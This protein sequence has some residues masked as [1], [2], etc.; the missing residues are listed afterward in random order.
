MPRRKLTK[1]QIGE[2]F[3]GSMFKKVVGVVKKHAKT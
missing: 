3:F 2:G 1:Q